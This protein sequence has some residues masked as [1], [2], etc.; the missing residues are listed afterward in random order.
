M[1]EIFKLFYNSLEKPIDIKGIFL[2]PYI[3]DDKIVWTYDNPADLSFNTYVLETCIE[4]LFYDFCKQTEMTLVPAF[5]I[6]WNIDS[7]KT[8]FINEELKSKIEQSLLEIKDLSYWDDNNSN[9]VCKSQM[10]Y[11][12]LSQEF[13]E[14]IFLEV[15]FNLYVIFID[16]VP[17]DSIKANKW[18]EGYMHAEE[19]IDHIANVQKNIKEIFPNYQDNDVEQLMSKMNEYSSHLSRFMFYKVDKN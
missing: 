10:D 4:D 15:G 12:E 11:W 2:F 8:L 9:L 1:E 18:L 5:P 7:P 3:Q 16:N 17:V 19:A 13:S 6:F 14:T